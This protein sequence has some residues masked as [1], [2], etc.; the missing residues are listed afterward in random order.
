M[1]FTIKPTVDHSCSCRIPVYVIVYSAKIYICIQTVKEGNLSRRRCA[2][3]SGTG[4]ACNGYCRWTIIGS[5]YP[6]PYI[7]KV[8]NNNVF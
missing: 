7:L 5:V 8:F 2:T 3:Y 4:Q 1:A 6:W